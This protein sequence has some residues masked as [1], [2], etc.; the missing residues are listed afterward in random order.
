[1]NSLPRTVLE[2]VKQILGE[3]AAEDKREVR[4]MP[5]DEL[6]QFHHGWGQGIRNSMGLWGRNPELLADTGKSHADDAS[7]VIIEAVWKALQS[8]DDAEIETSSVGNEK[9]PD[10]WEIM[11]EIENFISER[12]PRGVAFIA[13]ADDDDRM[14]KV[15]LVDDPLTELESSGV[16][17]F[18]DE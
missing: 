4:D 11:S 5:K 8:M 7:M 12:V 2:A 1:M 3:M 17:I 13:G 18:S 15:W 14:V 10:L 16:R 9:G 6:G